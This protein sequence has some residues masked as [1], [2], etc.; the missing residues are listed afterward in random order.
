MAR[1]LSD[2]KEGERLILGYYQQAV[3]EKNADVAVWDALFDYFFGA[4]KHQKEYL[5]AL[6]QFEALAKYRHQKSCK[7][8]ATASK[9]GKGW[10]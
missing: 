1:A 2:K 5:Y 4:K 7:H 8:M 3:R 6:Q 9:L 10:L